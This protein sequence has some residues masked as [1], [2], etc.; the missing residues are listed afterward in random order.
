VL[1][2]DAINKVFSTKQLDHFLTACGVKDGVIT[3]ND[4]KFGDYKIPFKSVRGNVPLH[5]DRLKYKKLYE[6]TQKHKEKIVRGMYVKDVFYGP[7]RGLK[8]KT[9]FFECTGEC[10]HD[11]VDTYIRIVKQK[12]TTKCLSCSHIQHGERAKVDGIIKKVSCNYKAWLS[13]KNKLKKEF[14]DFVYFRDYVGEKPTS[15][16]K[17]IHV[18]GVPM[19]FPKESFIEDEDTEL[20]STA[21]RRIFRQSKRYADCI[22]KSRVELES[23]VKYQC[24]LCKNL[25]PR[26]AIQVDHVDPVQPLDGSV[27]MKD[28]LINRIWN[29]EIQVLDRVC[30]AEKSKIENAQRKL[31]RK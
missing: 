23:G 7:D 21:I 6:L 29:A 28:Q 12:K 24:N 3:V 14:Q 26:S 13:I 18:D 10:G 4:A 5:K 15:R 1:D 31:A 27:L 17:I 20:V 30:H 22:K 9:Y 19:W 16:S 8:S 25:F 11:F 2:L